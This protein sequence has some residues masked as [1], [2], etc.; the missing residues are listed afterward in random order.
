MAYQEGKKWREYYPEK[1]KQGAKQVMKEAYHNKEPPNVDR[2]GF[3]RSFGK[4]ELLWILSEGG[5]GG[6]KRTV[7]DEL[8]RGRVISSFKKIRR[9]E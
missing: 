2:R 8:N 3:F 7:W 9:G 6:M 5:N 1:K 4:R